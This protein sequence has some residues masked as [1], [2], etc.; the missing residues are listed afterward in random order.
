MTDLQQQ[1]HTL[2][3]RMTAEQALRHSET[4]VLLQRVERL[5][6]AQRETEER[7]ASIEVSL[8][9]VNRRLDHLG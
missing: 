7:L 1:L 8:M 9:H 4:T 3:E 6:T 2:A 5:E